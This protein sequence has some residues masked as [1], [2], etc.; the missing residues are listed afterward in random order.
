MSSYVIFMLPNLKHY[1]KI[2]YE[3]QVGV[4]CDVVTL[5]WDNYYCQ[6]IVSP[7]GHSSIPFCQPDI[8]EKFY[9][10][11]SP[12]ESKIYQ[13]EKEISF[14]LKSFVICMNERKSLPGN[15]LPGTSRA[16]SC[17]QMLSTEFVLL[18]NCKAVLTCAENKI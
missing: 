18:T 10:T 6:N 2:I 5:Q 14:L 4:F 12:L 3:L 13:A 16:L 1:I 15:P 8:Q 9:S 11:N 7:S 17:W